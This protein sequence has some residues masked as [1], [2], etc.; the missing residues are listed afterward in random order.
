MSNAFKLS[1]GNVLL[2]TEA[3][4]GI[5][6]ASQL[7]KIAALCDRESIIVKATEDH[8]LALFV[9]PEKASEITAE[10]QSIGLGVRP[11]QE[12]LH[13]PVSCIGELCE[14]HEQDA[15]GTALDITSEL[16]AIALTS[17]LKIGING[18]AKCC[19]PCHTLDISIVGDTNGYRIS[20]GGK[21]SQL[22]EMASFMADSVPA[23]E[24]PRVVKTIVE[25]FKQKSQPGESL[26]ELIEREGGAAFVAA[27]A[28][29]SQD[30][31]DTADPFSSTPES[32]E[33]VESSDLADPFSS[34]PESGESSDLE[35]DLG[36]TS[37]GE[38][39]LAP[40]D[41]DLDLVNSNDFAE[42]PNF[43]EVEDQSEINHPDL[44]GQEVDDCELQLDDTPLD[45][46]SLNADQ[47][48][49]ITA[50][51]SGSGT[52]GIADIAVASESDDLS[53]TM[54]SDISVAD[55][56][57]VSLQEIELADET[58]E[59]L[60]AA[61]DGISNETEL[62]F[63]EACFDADE[64]PAAKNPGQELPGDADFGELEI[65][66][67]DEDLANDVSG[68]A[69]A[70]SN[71]SPVAFAS[72]PQAEALS[73]L[74]IDAGD[75]LNRS[76]AIAAVSEEL[77]S[78]DELSANEE[79]EA[80]AQLSDSISAQEQESPEELASHNNLDDGVNLLTS[81]ELSLDAEEETSDYE[82]VD[83][84][85][86]E[87][88]ADGEHDRHDDDAGENDFDVHDHL[89]L[90]EIVAT[91]IKH[92]TREATL[93]N[94][95]A[96]WVIASFDVD[97]QGCPVISWTNGI[98]VTVTEEAIAMGSIKIGGHNLRISDTHGGVL[99]EID[100]VRML[101]PAAA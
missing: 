69:P 99:V 30:A 10:L 7:K 14:D 93:P 65:K 75:I 15:L 83:E 55:G 50:A 98:S 64:T 74:V 18:C 6:N 51:S 81:S 8:R 40:L 4:G 28:P 5:Y 71:S 86:S 22:A 79:D 42:T 20:L 48:L 63:E 45:A 49:N 72:A 2:S 78:D 85:D 96:S 70:S 66:I 57:C 89:P 27:L 77:N 47:S 100:G 9:A 61:E 37:L 33:S 21:S 11:Y 68:L 13:Q 58:F 35:V 44:A 62:A 16:E 46:E 84:D 94:K 29:W 31:A 54:D 91:K 90:S 95:K 24:T 53:L 34:T 43:V 101:L 39:E 23:N 67:S 82:F 1:N 19:V 92:F 60:D 25:I 76:N 38:Q 59:D 52:E 41:E 36:D 80:L 3:P 88:S 17:V 32:A 26:Q 56:P 87:L 73:D 12:G 97:E